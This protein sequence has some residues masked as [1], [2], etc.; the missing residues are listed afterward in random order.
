MYQMHG[1]G[2]LRAVKTNGSLTELALLRPCR[3]G[4]GW[5]VVRS[6]TLVCSIAISHDTLLYIYIYI[7]CHMSFRKSR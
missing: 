5:S 6:S 1:I 3:D 7:I 4:L 2:R